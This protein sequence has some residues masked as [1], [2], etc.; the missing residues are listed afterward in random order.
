M[1]TCS[2]LLDPGQWMGYRM[3]I[4]YHGFWQLPHR[5]TGIPAGAQNH[6]CDFC[7]SNQILLF[8]D[9]FLIAAICFCVAVKNYTKVFDKLQ[10]ISS[11]LIFAQRL[12]ED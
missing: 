5:E 10:I 12:D 7:T 2:H 1:D 8:A 11:T 3:W 6:T 4:F 9:V